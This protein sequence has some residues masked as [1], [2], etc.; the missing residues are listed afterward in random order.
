[1]PKHL[2]LLN[3]M[4]KLNSGSQERMIFFLDHLTSFLKILLVR[5]FRSRESERT[6]GKLIE[7]EEEESGFSS[8]RRRS[9]QS[10]LNAAATVW[11]I[12][13]FRLFN[14]YLITDSF[15]SP[16]IPNIVGQL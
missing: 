4:Q 2:S 8:S 15:A 16:E 9:E 10:I 7:E 5:F 3:L 6:S 14:K 12:V 11:S 1:M 13:S